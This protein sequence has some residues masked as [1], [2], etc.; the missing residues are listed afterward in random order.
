MVQV[1]AIQDLQEE[2]VLEHLLQ[3]ISQ[4]QVSQ[5]T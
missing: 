3:V 1:E 4:N 2:M 5:I